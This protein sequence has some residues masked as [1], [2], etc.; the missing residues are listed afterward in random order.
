MNTAQSQTAFFF[1]SLISCYPFSISMDSRIWPRITWPTQFCKRI[2]LLA[3][4]NST[5][6]W[7]L[8][9]MLARTYALPTFPNLV[10]T[11]YDAVQ[12]IC[13]D[14]FLFVLFFCSAEAFNYT[15]PSRCLLKG[16]VKQNNHISCF[17]DLY[18]IKESHV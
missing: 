16:E 6:V 3:L 15:L 8:C 17:T 18:T 5:F 10:T 1:S 12:V 14:F 9:H 11:S 4:R 2:I 13:T 7:S